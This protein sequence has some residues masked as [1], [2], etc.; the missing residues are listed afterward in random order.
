M[1]E[2]NKC[3][4]MPNCKAILCLKMLLWFIPRVFS[5]YQTPSDLKSFGLLKEARSDW[6]SEFLK[7]WE[8][9]LIF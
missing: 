9:C 1:K 8:P 3:K 7:N 6:C 5:I 2:T 4:L